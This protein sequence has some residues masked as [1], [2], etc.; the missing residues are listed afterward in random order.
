MTMGKVPARV[1]RRGTSNSQANSDSCNSP[2]A[3]RG[4]DDAGGASAKMID[5]VL[6]GCVICVLTVCIFRCAKKVLDRK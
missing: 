4:G 2:E 5:I 3:N 6:A 1:L